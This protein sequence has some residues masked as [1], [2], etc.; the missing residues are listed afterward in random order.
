MTPFT[1]GVPHG[2]L[3]PSSSRQLAYK[4]I[5]LAGMYVHHVM[6]AQFQC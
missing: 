2:H 4:N 6:H 5:T 3:H 1:S